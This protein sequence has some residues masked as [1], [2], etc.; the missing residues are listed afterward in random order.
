MRSNI[1]NVNSFKERRTTWISELPK[2]NN[3][4]IN[5]LTQE[6]WGT[7]RP[8]DIGQLDI[9]GSKRQNKNEQSKKDDIQLIDISK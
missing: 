4:Y 2:N 1:T 3:W 8:K 6:E 5:T 7:G 9:I